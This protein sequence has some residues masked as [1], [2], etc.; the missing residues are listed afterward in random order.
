VLRSRH[1]TLLLH[2][3]GRPSH[4]AG[5]PNWRCVIDIA[6]VHIRF[7]EAGAFIRGK[8][9]V[10]WYTDFNSYS[11]YKRMWYPNIRTS[12][13][14]DEERIDILRECQFITFIPVGIGLSG[15]TGDM[16]EAIALQGLQGVIGADLPKMLAYAKDIAPPM[17]EHI[18]EAVFLAA[19]TKSANA[20][21][22]IVYPLQGVVH[23]DARLIPAITQI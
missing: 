2:S 17:R 5:A 21:G 20:H 15:I 19:F 11:M 23:T 4:D 7:Y 8:A 6:R 18:T 9:M 1:T 22:E 13:S 10:A 12:Y 16:D 14:K 3:P